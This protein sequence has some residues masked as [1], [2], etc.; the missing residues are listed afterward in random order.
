RAAMDIADLMTDEAERDSL[1]LEAVE[2]AD[3]NQEIPAEYTEKPL[4]YMPVQLTQS[5]SQKIAKA[6]YE[7]QRQ[8]VADKHREALYRLQIM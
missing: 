5:N 7:A 4:E 3:R 2:Q 1:W 6:I 8:N